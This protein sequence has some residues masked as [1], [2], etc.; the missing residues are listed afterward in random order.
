MTKTKRSSRAASTAPGEATT[1]IA[2]SPAAATPI[3]WPS[4]GFQWSDELRAQLPIVRGI[5][6]PPRVDGRALLDERV[7]V[8]AEDS[9]GKTEQM[10][11][12]LAQLMKRPWKVWR[13]ADSKAAITRE[14]LMQA[15]REYWLE[16]ARQS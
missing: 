14:R 2:P 9:S 16:H 12:E 1:T 7:L 10:F 3:E 5:H 8:L 13:T 6:A 15:D 11:A 4:G